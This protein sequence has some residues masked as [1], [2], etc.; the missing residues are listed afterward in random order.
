MLNQ[1]LE[2]L[3]TLKAQ[4]PV[5]LD[6]IE[7]MWVERTYTRK[8]EQDEFKLISNLRMALLLTA[9]KHADDDLNDDPRIAKR[10]SELLEHVRFNTPTLKFHERYTRN[11]TEIVPGIYL[12]ANFSCTDARLYRKRTCNI[13]LLRA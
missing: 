9:F 7:Y 1:A 3:A 6:H 5:V 10:L 13:T 12:H 8:R 11:A 4:T 2:K